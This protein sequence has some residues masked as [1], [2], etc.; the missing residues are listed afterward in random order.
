MLAVVELNKI[1]PHRISSSH[2]LL[3]FLVSANGTN[4]YPVTPTWNYPWLLPFPLSLPSVYKL[5]LLY[6]EAWCPYYHCLSL[7][8]SQPASPSM[9]LIHWTLWNLPSGNLGGIALFL[10]LPQNLTYII[11]NA[12]TISFN[13]FLVWMFSSW[14]MS[15]RVSFIFPPRLHPVQRPAL[16]ISKAV[17]KCLLTD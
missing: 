6:S 9:L 14:V 3:L 13:Y 7:I 10:M 16:S 15:D 5:S 4:T 1:E 12:L 11:T 8:C 2:L 17:H